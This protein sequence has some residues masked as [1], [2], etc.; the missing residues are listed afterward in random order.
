MTQ[1]STP[2]LA[3][4]LS[5]LSL[6]DVIEMIDWKR[7]SGTLELAPE[8]GPQGYIYFDRGR[9]IHSTSKESSGI[10]SCL[11]LMQIRRGTYAFTHGNP[12]CP[13]TIDNT[14]DELWEKVKR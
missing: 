1:T 2:D 4:S 8:T 10:D 3:G 9:V 7:H 14:L 13:R 11:R 12:P 6:R 5:Q